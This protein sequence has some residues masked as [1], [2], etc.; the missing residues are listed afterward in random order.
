MSVLLI[1]GTSEPRVMLAP[2]GILPGVEDEWRPSDRWGCLPVRPMAAPQVAWLSSLPAARASCFPSC[3]GPFPCPAQ[4]LCHPL[5]FSVM[6]FHY[7]S[8]LLHHLASHTLG[9]PPGFKGRASRISHRS[10]PAPIS[11]VT[12]GRLCSPATSAQT[13]LPEGQAAAALMPVAPPHPAG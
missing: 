9:S 13:L 4:C 7:L 2:R 6:V 10:S 1:H 11:L 8:P 3:R 12:V 5:V